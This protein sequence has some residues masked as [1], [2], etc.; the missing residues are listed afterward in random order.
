[1]RF[2]L[3][4]I[5]ESPKYLI[6]KGRDAEA[7]AVL[8][9]IAREN[10]RENS[11]TLEMLRA[12]EHGF[13]ETSSAATHPELGLE[14]EKEPGAH[15]ATAAAPE[16]AAPGLASDKGAAFGLELANLKRSLKQFDGRHVRMLFYSPRMTLNTCLVCA[17]TIASNAS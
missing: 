2:W 12:A 5:P 17:V 14:K 6:G 10:G 11:L 4:P 3:Y 1:M 9:F 13:T 7:I 16:P 15:D 8:D